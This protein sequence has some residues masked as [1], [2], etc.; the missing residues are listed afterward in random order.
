MLRTPES[1]V[2]K[3][4]RTSVQKLEP[5]PKEKLWIFPG[6]NLNASSSDPSQNVAGPAGTVPRQ[7]SYTYHFSQQ[8]GAECAGREY[9]DV[10]PG[11]VSCCEHIFGRAGPS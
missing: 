2:A 1:V 7:T 3:N 5:R 10:G 9:Q 11:D 4:F 6:T 8:K